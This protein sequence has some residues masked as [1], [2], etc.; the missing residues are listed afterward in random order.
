M[1]FG[2]VPLLYGQ[3]PAICEVYLASVKGAHGF[4]GGGAHNACQ[5]ALRSRRFALRAKNSA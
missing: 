3:R 5:L 1:L 2:D 4:V